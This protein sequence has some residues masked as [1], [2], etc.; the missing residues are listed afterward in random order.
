MEKGEQRFVDWVLQELRR[1][2]RFS[3]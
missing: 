3:A 2:P 1:A